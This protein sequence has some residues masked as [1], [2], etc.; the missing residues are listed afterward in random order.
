MTIMIIVQARMG[1]SRLPGKVM[2]PL[3]GKPLLERMLERVC[4]ARTAVI[5]SVATTTN[6]EDQPIRDLCA[7][8]GAR[9]YCGHPTDLLDRHYRAALPQRPDAV[10]K[11]PSDCPLIDPGVIDRVLQFYIGDHEQY[12]YVSNLHP[13][14]W[15]DGNDVEVVAFD[16]LARA[17]READAPLERE[18]TTPYLWNRPGLFRLGNVRWATGR[19]CSATHRWTIDYPEDY[20]FINA[21]YE[22]LW[23]PWRPIFS[24]KEILDLVEARPALAAVNARHAGSSWYNTHARELESL[25]RKGAAG[26]P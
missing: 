7:R 18:H 22:E 14:T 8:L 17:W 12:D 23:A 24:L 26:R 2:L 25:S 9:C 20:L 1:S 6:P 13:P 11:I 21:V 15:P 19:D 5:V 3:A 16:A 10:V 4:A